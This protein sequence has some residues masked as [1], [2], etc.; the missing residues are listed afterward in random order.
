MELINKD[1]IKLGKHR[2][3]KIDVEDILKA[4]KEILKLLSCWNTQ[5]GDIKYVRTEKY[6]VVETYNGGWS[7]NE[8]LEEDIKKYIETSSFEIE[9]EQHPI[10]ILKIELYAFIDFDNEEIK[11]QI[12][13][14]NS[15][16]KGLINPLKN[17]NTL[18][19][20]CLKI[21]NHW[22]KDYDMQTYEYLIEID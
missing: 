22:L 18:I 14:Y 2:V 10:M 8:E 5:Y 16:H 20:E 21:Q 17:V 3:F 12:E 7:E 13:I 4:N 6:L 9:Y 1:F 11:K 19:N 15:E